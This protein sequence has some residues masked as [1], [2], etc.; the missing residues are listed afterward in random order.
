MK[1]IK[2]GRG[3]S[4]MGGVS[5]ILAAVF[6]VVW[7]FAALS[8]G[9]GGIFAIFGIVFIAMAVMSAIYNL[10]NATGKNRYSSF[11]IT[12]DGEEI[13]PW[14]ER[15]GKR[16]DYNQPSVNTGESRYCPY[17]GVRVEG[18]F[19]YCNKCGKKLP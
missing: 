4:M 10:K 3:P 2:P 9:A 6:G 15:F 12:E 14:N 13:D 8:M 1:S 17:C 16:R 18:D 7:T 19:A 5:S 11:D